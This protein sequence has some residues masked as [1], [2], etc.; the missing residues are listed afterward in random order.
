MF[1]IKGPAPKQIALAGVLTSIGLVLH[2]VESL[3]PVFQILPGGKLGLAN[4]VTLVAFSW[5]GA[6][7]AL[8]VGLLRC[9]L[10][11]IFSGAVTM[12]LYSGMGTLCSVFLMSSAKRLFPEKISTVGRSML[13]AFAFNVGQVLVCALVLKNGYVFSYLPPLT[14]LAAVCGLLTGIAAKRTEQIIH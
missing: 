13:G 4:I 1:R 10:S 2:Y 3:M 8:L 11:S 14:I 9:F 5:Y 12:F 6:G 7:F